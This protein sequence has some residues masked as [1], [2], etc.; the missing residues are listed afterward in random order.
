MGLGALLF[1]IWLIATPLM[2]AATRKLRSATVVDAIVASTLLFAGLH[3][4]ATFAIIQ[5][6]PID[7]I[8]GEPCG[9]G[10]SR[11]VITSMGMM[12]SGGQ[13]SSYDCISGEEFTA[14]DLDDTRVTQIL[15]PFNDPENV[16]NL[17]DVKLSR[18]FERLALQRIMLRSLLLGFASGTVAWLYLFGWRWRVWIDR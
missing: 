14:L 17:G 7:N 2:F 9:D 4:L 5:R 11:K 16:L 1:L 3:V 8:T 18:V 12:E 6:G 13:V 15:R 10:G